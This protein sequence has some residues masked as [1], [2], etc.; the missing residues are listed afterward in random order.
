MRALA[1]L[2]AISHAY[3]ATTAGKQ[4]R[5]LLG[6][7]EQNKAKV[8]YHV[9]LRVES[10]H[11]PITFLNFLIQAAKNRKAYTE[12]SQA[13][14]DARFDSVLEVLGEETAALART[15]RHTLHNVYRQALQPAS[16]SD[17]QFSRL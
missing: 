10:S 13:E 15:I 4:D 1:R 9:K 7:T 17:I 5:E 8:P 14:L 6:N 3:L 12:S 11:H 2:H 16:R